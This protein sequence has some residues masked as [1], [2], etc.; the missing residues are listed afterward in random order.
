M[1]TSARG[2]T[3]NRALIFGRAGQRGFSLLEILVVVAIIAIF[4]GVAVLSTDLVAFERR[5]QQQ[6]V[7]FSTLLRYAG[8]EALMQTTDYGILFDE[9]GYRFLYLDQTVVPSAWRLLQSEILAPYQLEDDMEFV[10]WLDDAEVE[11]DPAELL[12]PAGET[13]DGLPPPYPPPHVMLLS[14]GEVTPFEL[15]FLRSSELLEPGFV[16]AVAFDGRSEIRRS[17]F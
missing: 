6:A 1:P 12:V 5:L 14:S 13:E 10:L 7:R 3:S 16:L 8:E 11:L 4:V 17:E 9:T 2:T 15:E